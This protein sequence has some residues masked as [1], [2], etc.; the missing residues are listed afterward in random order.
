MDFDDIF[1]GHIF[2]IFLDQAGKKL[3]PLISF[4]TGIKLIFEAKICLFFK[5]LSPPNTIYKMLSSTIYTIYQTF[6]VFHVVLCFASLSGFTNPA[7][8]E[9]LD[10]M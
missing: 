5:H 2:A 10:Q 7:H 9:D 1:G 8:A 3:I 4:F 6:L